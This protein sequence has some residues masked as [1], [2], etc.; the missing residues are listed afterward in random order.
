MKKALKLFASAALLTALCTPIAACNRNTQ[1][2]VDGPETVVSTKFSQNAFSTSGSVYNFMSSDDMGNIV[3]QETTANVSTGASIVTYKLFNLKTKRFSSF[4]SSDPIS[5]ITDGF[6]Y[7]VK[8]TN[9][10]GL[11]LDP[12]EHV[13]TLYDGN[14]ILTSNVK[15]EVRGSMFVQTDGTRWYVNINNEVEK[16]KN[17]FNPV[18]E[19]NAMEVGDFYVVRTSSDTCQ[20][21]NEDGEFEYAFSVTEKLNLAEGVEINT[22]WTVQNKIFAQVYAALPDD[23]KKYDFITEENGEMKKYD[24]MTYSYSLKRDNVKE[25]KNFDYFVED[26]YEENEKSVILE[27]SEIVDKRISQSDIIQ[28][29]D[30]NANIAFN[31][32]KLVPGACDFESFGDYV[33]FDDLAGFTHIYKERK[34]IMSVPSSSLGSINTVG[35][36][37]YYSISGTLSVYSLEEGEVVHAAENVTNYGKTANGNIWYQTYD[38]MTSTTRYAVYDVE[39]DDVDIDT[40]NATQQ[41][42]SS[43]RNYY[44]VY[45][46]TMNSYTICFPD[47]SYSDITSSNPIAVVGSYYEEES[48][49]IYSTHIIFCT[50]EGIVNNYHV[51]T[52]SY[53]PEEE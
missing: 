41:I 23:A 6:F 4:M 26:V 5:M 20:V 1:K 44:I 16:E 28:A 15:G 17:P 3:V 32:Q 13:Y 42:V 19:N 43:T 46:T 45:N 50:T 21:F 52:I 30:Q 51:L 24:L 2:L 38:A 25:I 7:S 40:Y 33:R 48:E 39:E 8:T 47:S 34:L 36:C 31:I 35:D 10:D 22:I 27:V 18:L 29:F 53:A 37:L 14:S 49:D 9:V 12:S 11:P